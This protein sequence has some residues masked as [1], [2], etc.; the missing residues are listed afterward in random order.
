MKGQGLAK[1]REYWHDVVGY[2]YRMTNICAAIGSAQMEAIEAVIAM[3]QAVAGWYREGLAG[4]PVSVHGTRPGTFNSYWM[5]SLLADDPADRDPLRAHLR[6]GGVE[7]RPLFPPMHLMPMYRRPGESFP[8]AESLSARGMNLPSYPDLSKAD[9]AA[10]C[11][12]IAG[13]FRNA[14]RR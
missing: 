7:T 3:K 1:D 10:I 11:D 6:A 12:A 5:V 9:V 14:G 8:R 4:L 2:N 13:Y